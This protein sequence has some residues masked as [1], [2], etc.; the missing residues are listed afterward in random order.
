ME[1][2]Y[3]KT[4][5]AAGANCVCIFMKSNFGD[6]TKEFYIQYKKE[7]DTSYTKIPVQHKTSEIITFD[8]AE[9]L[10]VQAFYRFNF[11]HY[12]I[13]VFNLEPST[14]Y[15]FRVEIQ[16]GGESKVVESPSVE[17]CSIG[18]FVHYFA[19]EIGEKPS[20]NWEDW[21]NEGVKNVKKAI[22]YLEYAGLNTSIHSYI[23]GSKYNCKIRFNWEGAIAMSSGGGVVTI[24]KY[25]EGQSFYLQFIHEL[26]HEFGITGNY[27]GTF[28][29]IICESEKWYY[30]GNNIYGIRA[31]E[32][33][34]LL[35]RLKTNN[36]KAYVTKYYDHSNCIDEGNLS[37]FLF[38]PC[39][40]G[41]D[42]TIIEND[43]FS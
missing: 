23:G 28:S 30:W 13:E 41:N 38:I 43:Y 8:S 32:N 1:E 27:G 34:L 31:L 16:C 39:L 19:D 42:I 25:G 18:K 9:G 2:Y 22:T 14:S 17:T 21:Y 36:K 29:G 37:D 33:S 11:G 20:Y 15:K 5:Y 4:A 3:I 40:Y 35:F 10:G 12:E 6:S 24:S 26:R 7:S